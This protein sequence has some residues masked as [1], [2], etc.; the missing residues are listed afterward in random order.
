MRISGSVS[1]LSAEVTLSLVLSTGNRRNVAFVVDTGFLGALALPEA[2]LE[3]LG[4]RV[5]GQ[6]EATLADGSSC[7]TLV[8]EAR[9]AWGEGVL[10]VAALAMGDRPLLGTALL[11]ECH[12]GIDF[13][14]G[15]TVQIN[16][17]TR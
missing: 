11:E 13:T 3:R 2:D 14:E 5:F 7:S 9:V 17:L 6:T 16:P 4:L 10:R 1:A 12:L 15:G 8:Y